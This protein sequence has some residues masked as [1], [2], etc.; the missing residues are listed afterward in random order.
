MA[1]T[2]AVM[3]SAD[4]SKFC[5]SFERSM[6]WV[7]AC[8]KVSI[9]FD[10]RLVLI[11]KGTVSAIYIRLLANRAEELVCFVGFEHL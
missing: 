1:C 5:G 2:L 3:D 7:L 11:D 6:S 4:I 8:C 10:F 9:M